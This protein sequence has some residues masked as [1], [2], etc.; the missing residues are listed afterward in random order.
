M[1]K[2][3]IT[4]VTFELSEYQMR[5]VA[6]AA[7]TGAVD[8]KF[9]ALY[10][11]EQHDHIEALVECLNDADIIKISEL[12]FSKKMD[13]QEAI[14]LF[15]HLERDTFDEFV[16]SSS[17]DKRVLE[18]AGGSKS[19]VAA[20]SKLNKKSEEESA[21][22]DK[23]IAELKQKNMADALA[24]VKASGLYAVTPLAKQ[25]TP[26]LKK[27]AINVKMSDVQ[28]VAAKRDVISNVKRESIQKQT[29]FSGVLRIAA[30]SKGC[31]P[32]KIITNALKS[33]E[34][35]IKLYQLG[36]TLQC[37]SLVS[38]LREIGCE[39]VVIVKP[40]PGFSGPQLF[41]ISVTVNNK[42]VELLRMKNELLS[43]LKLG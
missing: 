2:T 41:S 9:P 43:E 33:G 6:K 30:Q 35:R 22:E 40:T 20:L 14:E 16:S 15:R 19:I 21:A 32:S 24:L 12:V 25:L 13:E 42:P 28:K 38:L 11:A 27:N 3:L 31:V 34:R 39:Q 36:T 4:A 17:A 1:S 23:R 37:Q 10:S 26:P 18:W 29:T 7:L 8:K 5:E